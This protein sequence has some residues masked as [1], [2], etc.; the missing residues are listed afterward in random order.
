[1]AGEGEGWGGG[2]TGGGRGT[3]YLVGTQKMFAELFRRIHEYKLL[4]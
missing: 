2:E 1:M 3:L 4:I